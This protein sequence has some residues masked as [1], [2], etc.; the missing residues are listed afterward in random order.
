MGVIYDPAEYGDLWASIYDEEHAWKDPA[1]S[2]EFLTRL[3]DQRRVL[4]LG[5]G[6]GRIAIP[7]SERGIDVVGLD[8]SLEMVEKMRQKPGGA[9]VEVLIGDMATS[10]LGGPYGLVFVAFN[11]IFGLVDQRRQVDCFRNV[12]RALGEGGRFA[13]ECYVPDLRR[14]QEGNQAVRVLPTSRPERLRLNA[15]LHFPDEQRIE[16]HVVVI[17]EGEVQVLPVSLRYIWPSELDL[18]AQLAGF[19]LEDRYGGWSGEPFNAQ[20]GFHVSVYRV[21]DQS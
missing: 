12:R 5:V 9:D 16:T 1:A 13:L 20:S 6:T 15:A 3:A 8:A 11:T 7:L 19:E 18:M 17:A 10:D 21:A 2:V 14:F 4:E